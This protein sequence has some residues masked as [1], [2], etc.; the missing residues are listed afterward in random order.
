MPWLD[1][2]VR[3]HGCGAVLPPGEQTRCPTCAADLAQV[4]TWSELQEWGLTR[5]RGRLRFMC[6][7]VALFGLGAVAACGV[8]AWRGDMHPVA[9]ALTA[10]WPVGGYVIGRLYWRGA[11][12]EYATWMEQSSRA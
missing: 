7:R 4:G 1:P 3:C 6:Q 9:Y 5:Q 2:R 8:I 11:E 10:L 12:R